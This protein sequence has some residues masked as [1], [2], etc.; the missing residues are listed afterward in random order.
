M[1]SWKQLINEALDKCNNEQELASFLEVGQ[2]T[3]NNWKHGIVEPHDKKRE[4]L[5]KKLQSLKSGEV[6]GGKIA[7]EM[8]KDLEA[9]WK[10]ASKPERDIIEAGLR[11]AW[12]SLHRKIILNLLK[13]EPDLGK[14]HGATGHEESAAA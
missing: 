3:V 7:E 13:T 11:A 1:K 2:Q 14:A 6:K 5:F 8:L 12:P 9:R 4:R 10:K